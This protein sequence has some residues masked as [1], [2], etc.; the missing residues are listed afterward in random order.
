ML[1]DHFSH[2]R[3]H[4]NRIV[5]TSNDLNLEFRPFSMPHRVIIKQKA[6]N[7]MNG[8]GNEPTAK[9]LAFFPILLLLLYRKLKK[10]EK[11]C[12]EEKMI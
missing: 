8:D 3:S 7:S 4:N 5:D 9:K 11:N 6:G 10:I 12:E 2:F 1:R